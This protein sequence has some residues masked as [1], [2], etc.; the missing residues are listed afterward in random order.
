MT[1]TRV[2]GTCGSRPSGHFA[3]RQTVSFATDSAAQKVEIRDQST[4]L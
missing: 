1:R 2:T 4:V 3:T